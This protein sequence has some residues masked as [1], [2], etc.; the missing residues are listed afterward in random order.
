VTLQWANRA[1]QDLED[2]LGFIAV[3]NPGAA[4][5]LHD[6]VFRKTDKLKDFPTMGPVST[7][8]GEPFHEV[9]VKP[10]RILYLFEDDTVTIVA[11]YREE[12]NLRPG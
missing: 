1:L 6:Q 5:R 10:L 2:L 3:D 9:L 8:A 7:E 4:K 11:V 12:A